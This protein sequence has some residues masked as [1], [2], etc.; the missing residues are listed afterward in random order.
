VRRVSF[1]DGWEVRQKTNRFAEMIGAGAE[2]EAVTLPHDAVI[3]TE[4][5]R[6]A[7]A[8]TGFYSGGTWEYRKSFE[9]TAEEADTAII[10]EFE[11]V[12]RDATV[13]VNGSVAGRR[14][15]GYSSFSL[16]VDHLLRYGMQNELRVDARAHDDSRWYSG[17]GIYRNVWLLRAGRLHLAAG[18][19]RIA[20]PEIDDEVAAVTVDAVVRNQS[21]MTAEADLRVEVVDASGAT[22]ARVECPVTTL[23][24]DT[25]TARQRLYVEA[26]ERWGLDHPYL[27]SCRVSLLIDGAAVDEE[28]ATFG[29]RSLAV[30]PIRGLRINAEP[31]LLRGACVHHD[32]GPLGAATIDRAEERRVMLLKDAGFNA[33]RS[34]HNPISNAMLAACDRLGMI[35]MDE[36]F[37]VWTQSKSDDDYALRF[38]QWW[39]QDIEAM[40]DKDFNHPSVVFYSIGNE[41]PEVGEPTGARHGRALARAV[42]AL[43]GTRF[44]TQAISGLLVGGAELLGVLRSQ[45]ETDSPAD[46]GP[47]QETGVNTAMT[48]L[49][50]RLST[51]MLSPLIAQKSAETASY[52]D[53]A[54]YNYME[55][56][57]EMDA[58]RFPNRVI[59]ASETHAPAIDSGW[60]GVLRHPHVIG[61]FTWTGW[62]YLG[63]AGIGRVD[64]GEPGRGMSG[65][66]GEFPWLTA[67]CGDIDITGHRRPQ[68]FYRE[69]V[70]GLRSAP[71]L[72]V[73]RPLPP[74]QVVVHSSPWSWSDVVSSWSWDGH[75]GGPMTVEVYAGDDEVELLVNGRS[76]GRR[77]TGC[78]HRFRAEFEL[79]FEAGLLEAVAWRDGKEIGRTSLRSAAGP[80][81]LDAHADRA[82]IEAGPTD[83]AFVDLMLVDGEGTP[84]TSDARPITVELDGPGHL[85]GFGSA[86]PRGDGR[87]TGTTCMSFEGRALAVIRPTGEGAI[88]LTATAEGCEPGQ[89]RIDARR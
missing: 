8:A 10:L 84:C 9:V 57:F 47:D 21:A 68:S 83:L 70:F 52:L 89:V 76:L 5:S 63:E 19:V 22:V 86:D 18:G 85:Q 71:Y 54:G 17:A 50:G 4:R 25:C 87:F 39:E 43:D 61:D 81:S 7:S 59:V 66:L 3:G 77:P 29:I 56:R 62:D 36:A 31:V 65:F 75:S 73:R 1:N 72:A 28:F 82:Q 42:H 53:V 58:K 64:Y 30:D 44:V 80:V 35:V 69:I 34:A 67:W 2:W 11:G 55:L 74:G 13:Y 78:A 14:P 26:P 23:P 16:Q 60:S 51:L 27:Y 46:A 40:V 24:G 88:T 15:Y 79:E 12:Y 38:A 32:N 48:D 33:I 6:S 45:M 37:D 41:I 49:A 20:T